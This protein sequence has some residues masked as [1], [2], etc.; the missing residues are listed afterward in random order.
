[1]SSS[2]DLSEFYKYSRPKKPPCKI[3]AIYD[4]L[5]PI[6]Q[7]QLSAAVRENAGLITAGA[8]YTWLT[9]RLA[10][11]PKLPQLEISNQNVVSH[12]KGMCTCD[13]S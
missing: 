7:E 13:D 11:N 6:Q 12:R 9:Q 1:M 2:V 8:I 4:A 10:E 5:P 3:R